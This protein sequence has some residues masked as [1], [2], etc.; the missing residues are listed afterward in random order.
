ML[1]LNFKNSRHIIIISKIAACAVLIFVLA[2]G[3]KTSQ[4]SA[5]QNLKNLMAATEYL[6]LGSNINFSGR[7]S[8]F[9]A[10]QASDSSAAGKPT[11]AQD[12]AA[13]PPPSILPQTQSPGDATA[14]T[15]IKTAIAIRPKKSTRVPPPD[16]PALSSVAGNFFLQN[17]W[18]PTQTTAYKFSPL[19]REATDMLY[20]C[21]TLCFLFGAYLTM[22]K[23][24][25]LPISPG[26]LL[27]KQP[28][29]AVRSKNSI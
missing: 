9:P 21:A 2:I 7:L 18:Q 19:S 16:L 24:K 14:P 25:P 23:N 4:A 3:F 20:A 27:Y 28:Q 17:F 6:S 5:K 13:N 22:A 8:F 15:Q 12:N 11:V 29:I 26:I 10:A 1:S